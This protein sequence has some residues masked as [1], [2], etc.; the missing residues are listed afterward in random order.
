MNIIMSSSITLE[1]IKQLTLDC[2][3]ILLRLQFNEEYISLTYTNK[4]MDKTEVKWM[5]SITIQERELLNKA[6]GMAYCTNRVCL[7]I[8]PEDT[9]RPEVIGSAAQAIASRVTDLL[10]PVVAQIYEEVYDTAVDQITILN[11]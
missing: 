9:K 2:E 6:L 1:D 7:E 10:T 5:D 8:I 3:S 4:C 11:P